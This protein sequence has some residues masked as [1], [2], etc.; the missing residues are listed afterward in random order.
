[1]ILLLLGTAGVLLALPGLTQRLGRRLAPAEWARL[2][3]VALG[4]GLALTELALVMRAAPASLR[5][6]GA[7]GLAA[8]CERVVSPLLSGGPLVTG[9]AAAA[10]SGLPVA[11]GVTC[12]R[13]RRTRRRIA[14]ELWLGERRVVAGHEVVVVPVRRPFAASFEQGRGAEVVV[15]STGLFDVLGP[16]HIEA[17][18]RHEAAHLRHRHQ[19]LL[20]LAAVSERVLGRV[21]GVAASAAALRL[22][23][24]R[25]ADE[26]A[27]RPS[28]AAR[29][30]VRDSLLVLAGA[31]EGV[32][33]FGD[34]LTVAARVDALDR[35]E[36]PPPLG[37]HVLLYVPGSLSG[38]LAA[39]AVLD[40]TA[41]ARA[42]LAA[43]A[44][45]SI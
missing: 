41:R 19:R 31:V 9:L 20:T 22:A 2:C 38:L 28:A 10:A 5:A 45:C 12:G 18:V 40:W 14:R 32:A 13:L 43:S 33:S 37:H 8:A 15:V 42:A 4:G 39:P 6:V 27:A 25:W 7:G 16:V 11:A 21:P 3:A 44:H 30:A 36:P 29:R 1:M 26:L 35:P 24:E 23:V 17:V 34:A